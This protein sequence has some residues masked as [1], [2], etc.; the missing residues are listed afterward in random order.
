MG[1]DVKQ[2][3]RLPLSEV[4][5]LLAG[6]LEMTGKIVSG[7]DPIKA[8]QQSLAQGVLALGLD[9]LRKENAELM[10]KS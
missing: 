2:D 6:F 4:G 5:G 9:A 10:K 3:N 1:L 7:Q 8:V